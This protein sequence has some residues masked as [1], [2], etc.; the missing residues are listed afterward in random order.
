M[1]KKV[2]VYICSGCGIDQ[3][4]DLD[5]LS[6]VATKEMKAAK[7]QTH[8][9]LCSDEGLQVIKEDIKT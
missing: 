8:P 7:C 4:V 6:K 5:Q 2:G 9:F 3:A 1:E